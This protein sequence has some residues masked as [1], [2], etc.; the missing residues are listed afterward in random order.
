MLLQAQERSQNL[1]LRVFSDIQASVNLREFSVI[2]NGFM[3]FSISSL[4]QK[5]A[6][7]EVHNGI[8]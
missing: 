1:Q 7:P 3:Y 5:I 6:C 4:A 2:R 8:Y